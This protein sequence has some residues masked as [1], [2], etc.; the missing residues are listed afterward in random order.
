[1]SEQD[2]FFESA[3]GGRKRDTT[4]SSGGQDEFFG[5]ALKKP[6]SG[7]LPETKKVESENF[8]WNRAKRDFAAG[9]AALADTPARIINLGV[10]GVGRLAGAAGITPPDLPFNANHYTE[11]LQRALG[12]GEA[13]QPKD[14]GQ[15]LLG[16]IVGGAAAGLGGGLPLAGALNTAKTL[17]GAVAQYAATQGSLGA[18]AGAGSELGGQAASA[19]SPELGPTG[20]VIGGLVGGTVVPSSFLRY[21]GPVV[22]AS[23]AAYEAS[24]DMIRSGKSADAAA[25]RASPIVEKLVFNQLRDSVA[26]TPNAAQNIDDALAISGKIPGFRPSVAEMSGSAAAGQMQSKYALTSPSRMNAEIARGESNR[27][28]IADYY[29]SIAPDSPSPSSIRSDINQSLSDARKTALSGETSVAGRLP[30]TDQLQ[31]GTRLTDLAN[32]AKIAA[33]PAITKAYDKAFETSGSAVTSA[34]PIVKMVE[35]ILGTKLSQVKPENSPQTVSAIQRILGDKTQELTGR[36]IPPD[37]MDKMGVGTK[38]VT[39]KDLHEI[40]V[41]IGQDMAAAGRSLDPTAATRL[42]NLGKVMPEIDAAI[43][44]LPGATAYSAAREK[45]KTEYAPRFKEGT[46]LQVFKDKSTNEPRILPDLFIS[47]FLKPDVSAGVT[48]A[49]QFKQLFGA[50]DE[51]KTLANQ[52]IMDTYRQKV[53]DPQTGVI[54]EAAHAAFM[55]DYGRTLLTF[56]GQG[57]PALSNLT[58]IGR[59][60]A[61]AAASTDRITQTAKTLKFDTVDDLVNAAIKDTKVMGNALMRMTPESRSQM[62]KLIMDKATQGGTAESITKFLIDNEKTLKM[63]PGMNATHKTNL[64]DIAKAYEITERAPLRGNVQTG[65]PDLI[66]NET[67]TSS[68]TIQSQIRAWT[69]GRQAFATGALNVGIPMLYRLSQTKFTDVMENALHNPKTAESLRD[70]LRASTAQQA[71]NAAGG[72]LDSMKSVGSIVWSARGP[73]LKHFIGVEKYP[74]NLARTG[75]VIAADIQEEQ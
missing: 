45:Y 18:L 26:G 12:A 23:R 3:L 9:A 75:E 59:E 51:A 36:S 68:A 17:P 41:A 5:A 70:F 33:K 65:G 72:I 11:A 38:N 47:E 46:N 44:T 40:R 21:G 13:V 43:G 29:K 73:V 56:E 66:K 32:E 1:M 2:A 34:A 61:T 54:K 42:Y 64:L 7:M 15:A 53:V 31:L 71:N 60:A 6:E 20:S 16:S 39:M 69:G 57:V 55:R 10:A 48:R 49:S 14:S 22:G 19:I 67:G 25:A 74:Q 4:P 35:D 28:A 63:I 8:Y 30:V 37:L 58:R 62:S 52:G 50:N 27:Q 24:K